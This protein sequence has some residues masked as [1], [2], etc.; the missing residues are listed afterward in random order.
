MQ[1]EAEAITEQQKELLKQQ[2]V[3]RQKQL[4]RQHLEIQQEEQRLIGLQKVKTTSAINVTKGSDDY[5]NVPMDLTMPVEKPDY[6]EDEESCKGV[7]H[8]TLCWTMGVPHMGHAQNALCNPS[9]VTGC[10]WLWY[11]ASTLRLLAIGKIQQQ[12]DS[13]KMNL[14]CFYYIFY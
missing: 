3:Q 11:T 1:L 9:K 10:T 8:S 7:N 4:G 5:E 6:Y 2:E 13:H 14:Q 12:F